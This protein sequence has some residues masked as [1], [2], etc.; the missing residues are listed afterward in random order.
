MKR[1]A[2]LFLSAV[3]AASSLPMTA[4]AAN[5]KDIDNVPWNGAQTVINQVA[6]LGLLGGYEDNTFRARNNVTYCEAMQ[7]VY[8]VMTKTGSAEPIAAV[9]AYP[10]MAILNTYKVPGWAQMAVAYGLH[11]N[12]IDMQMV[13]SKFAG[14]QKYA[15]REDVAKMFGNAMAQFY[16]KERDTPDAFTFADSWRISKEVLPQ[17]DILKRLGIINGDS[18]NF[19]NPGMNIN[20]AEM[21]V[22]LNKT[23][24]VL[25][26]G[27]SSSGEITKIIVNEDKYYFIEVTLENGV[28]EVSVR[29]KAVSLFMQA[30]QQQLF[31]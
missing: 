13:V 1:R 17:V 24:G 23:N 5:F 14:G 2:V 6:D 18:N 31:L 10:Y 15:T 26:E 28:K 9:D 29:K 25:T 3:M 4:Y 21:A 7:M 20:R 11:N 19:F 30:I 27:V 12:I 8:K 22:M 16:D